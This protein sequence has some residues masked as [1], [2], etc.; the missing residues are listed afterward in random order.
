[1]RGKKI[2]TETRRNSRRKNPTE[3]VCTG[4][5]R[6]LETRSWCGRIPLSTVTIERIITRWIL[7]RMRQSPIVS[8]SLVCVDAADCVRVFPGEEISA[9]D[10]GGGG[11]CWHEIL[12]SSSRHALVEVSTSNHT[13]SAVRVIFLCVNQNSGH[14]FSCTHTK[15]LLDRR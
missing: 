14:S 4:D 3:S 6:N 11:V 13:R 8:L 12:S 5:V 9:C 1:M 7:R 10:G 15:L 2:E